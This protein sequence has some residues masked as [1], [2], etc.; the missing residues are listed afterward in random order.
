MLK[1]ILPG[2]LFLLVS[3]NFVFSQTN[4]TYNFLRLDVG[5]RASSLGGSFTAAENDVNVIFYNPGAIST[6]QGKQASVGFY[7]Y[8]LD[9]NSGNAAYV[10]SYPGIGNVG[11]GIQ[12]INYGSF[13]RYD[14]N[15][16]NT[17]TFGASD[18]AISF[19]IGNSYNNLSYGGNLKFIYSSYDTY[20]STAVA[21]DLGA[22]YKVPKAMMAFGVSLMN[23]GTQISKYQDYSEKLPLDLRVGIT[24]KLENSPLTLNV[25]F[26]GLNESYDKFFDR[27]KN[28]TAGGEFSISDNINLR[29]GY[30]NQLRQQLKTGSAIGIGG[31]SAGLGIKLQEKYQIDYGF[32]SMGKLGSTHRVNLGFLIK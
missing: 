21:L 1:K 5:A 29:V 25:G 9:I 26:Y 3:S 6:V 15:S 2:I 30:D 14:V 13:D 17:G 22:L 28:V 23:L 24:K 19:G 20:K 16:N 4:T 32:N 27:F 7:K 31:F 8:L 10:Q 18:I 11:V 12:Y